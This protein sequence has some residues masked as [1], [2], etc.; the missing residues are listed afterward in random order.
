MTEKTAVQ[1]VAD[2]LH[3]AHTTR[4]PIDSVSKTAGLEL[5]VADAYQVQ[6]INIERRLKSGRRI[7]GCKVGLTSL[8]MQRMLGVD[9]PDFGHILDDMVIRNGGR[10]ATSE[11]IAP[12]VEPE[13]AFV[14]AKALRGPGVSRADVLA[15][16]EYV[17]PALEIIDT[18]IKDWKIGLVDTIADNASSAQIVLGD[19]KT[20]PRDCDLRLVGMILEK[21]GQL[22]E[23]GA[24][25]AALGHPAE[26]VAWLV[27]KLGEFGQQIAAGSIVMPGA[28]CR[29]ID[30]VAGDSVTAT[31]D[32]LGSVQ[33]SFV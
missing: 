16:T 28:L 3:D 24:G 2:R 14:L 20:S 13:I 5:S 18:R 9:Q 11:L 19:Q 6:L 4:R 26:A 31:F 12:R 7:V 23:T 15:A 25:A 27:K 8:A 1:A 33:V 21:N 10:C 32:R 30:V 22:A 17:T 29:A